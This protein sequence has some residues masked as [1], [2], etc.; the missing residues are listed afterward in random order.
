M[1]GPATNSRQKVAV[2][3]TT[4]ASAGQLFQ[5]NG[6]LPSLQQDAYQN[7]WQLAD[8]QDAR[9]QR[10]QG[11]QTYFVHSYALQGSITSLSLFRPCMPLLKQ[12]FSFA[13]YANQL[14]G[15]LDDSSEE[16][17]WRDSG[18][19]RSQDHRGSHRSDRHPSATLYVRVRPKQSNLEME[20]SMPWTGCHCRDGRRCTVISGV[21]LSNV[22]PEK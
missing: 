15:G 2:A 21:S 20:L 9:Q 19:D 11:S 6:G 14:E 16:G 3:G 10:Q 18:D 8:E 4:F 12:C 17:A 5:D 13:D 22:N 1:S 7:R